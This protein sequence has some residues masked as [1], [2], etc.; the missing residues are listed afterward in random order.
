MKSIR[1]LPM[2]IMAAFALLLLKGLEIFTQTE[3]GLSGTNTAQAQQVSDLSDAEI[4]AADRA[5]QTLFSR[6]EEAPINSTQIDAI[7][8]SEN[9][10]GDKI[11]IGSIDGVNETEKA[12]LERLS[13]RRTELDLLSEQIEMRMAL[14]EAA[15]KRLEQRA[16]GLKEIEARIEALVNERKALDDEQFRA[17]ISMYET[18]KPGDAAE[19]FNELNMNILLK[20]ARAINPRKM[21]PILAKMDREKAMALTQNMASIKTEPN[22]AAPID[23]IEN[24]PQIIGQ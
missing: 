9:K 20:V 18:M 7:P 13:E 21:A 22:F 24:L 16:A 17:L 14:V 19:I 8:M 10:Y 12:I 1:L 23:D 2:V 3:S 11:P 6:Q 4:K 5:A 15:E